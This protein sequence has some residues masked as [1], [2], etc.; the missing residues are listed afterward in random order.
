M[1]Q[2]SGGPVAI[3]IVRPY[4]NEDE[5]LEHELDTLGRAG[6]VLIGADARPAGV[7]LRFEVALQDGSPLVRGEGRVLAFR[8]QVIGDEPG[9]ALRFTKLDVKSKALVDRASAL[10]E[11]RK[12]DSNA[13][14]RASVPGAPPPSGDEGAPQLDDAQVQS[15]TAPPPAAPD[16][17]DALP[18]LDDDDEQ[19]APGEVTAVAENPAL[20]AAETAG[21]PRSSALARLRRRAEMLDDERRAA[22]LETLRR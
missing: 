7:I 22:L 13:D 8:E 19:G 1:A 11:E 3:R 20:L 4:A 17:D 2:A 15:A 16:D 6:I 21:D 18:R 14:I 12:R 5:F 10:R 9:L